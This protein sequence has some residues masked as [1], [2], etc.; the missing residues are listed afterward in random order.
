MRSILL[1]ILFFYCGVSWGQGSG[2]SFSYTGPTQILVGQDCV[3]ELNWG[4][5]NTP[6]VSSNLPGGF[7]VSFNIYSI[8]GG[9]QM[10]DEV[11]GG[12]VVTVFYQA[13]D[14]FGNSAL[15]GFTIT[16]TDNIPPTFD[17]LSLPPNLTVNCIANF[18]VANVEVHDNCEDFD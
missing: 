10:G 7:I 4:H 8:S 16:F 12:S 17:P 6:T 11:S 3:A 5:P 15:F 2:F 9:Y 18:P 1:L 13:I 14:N